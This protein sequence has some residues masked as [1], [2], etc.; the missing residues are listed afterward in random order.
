MLPDTCTSSTCG[1]SCNASCTFCKIDAENV[2]AFTQTG[3]FQNLLALQ[4]AV[5][6]HVD[7]A[8]LVIGVFEEQPFR[9]VPDAKVD[10]GHKCDE[11][12][13]FSRGTTRMRRL[14]YC[15]A[16]CERTFT[17]SKML[18]PA[19]SRIGNALVARRGSFGSSLSFRWSRVARKFDDARA[20]VPGN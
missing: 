14:R 18:L 12:A 10:A 15:V 11:R 5:R 8:Q 19:L 6:L 9:A 4:G 13:R 16:L 1:S 20:Q 2:F 7:L 17:S 3:C